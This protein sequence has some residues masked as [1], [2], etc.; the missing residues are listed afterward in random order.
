MKTMTQDEKRIKI[1]EA[2]GWTAISRYP[3]PDDGFTWFGFPPD[4]K[5]MRD[6]VSDYFGDLNACHEMEKCM[7]SSQCA[8]YRD[9]VSRN[10]AC[11]DDMIGACIDWQ[12][13]HATAAQRSEAFGRTL[14][15][16]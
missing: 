13:V 12:L 8:A 2:C 1:A 15:L 6:E 9:E 16:W 10:P 3:R 7:T 5:T 14:N 11:F 4:N